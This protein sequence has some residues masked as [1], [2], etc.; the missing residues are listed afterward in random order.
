MAISLDV[1]LEVEVVVL[2]DY[3]C[4]LIPDFC[5]SYLAY[6]WMVDALQMR[7]LSQDTSWESVILSRIGY[8][9]E[10]LS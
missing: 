3:L 2:V 4:Q 5:M 10:D 7:D 1:V 9:Q 8:V 6:V